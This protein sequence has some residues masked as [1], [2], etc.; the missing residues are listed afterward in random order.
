MK[1]NGEDNRFHRLAA[2]LVAR[3]CGQV[4]VDK[5]GSSIVEDDAL[6]HIVSLADTATPRELTRPGCPIDRA[7][8]QWSGGSCRCSCPPWA[9]GGEL[10]FSTLGVA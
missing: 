2:P 3:A 7:M 10:A 8:F 1:R 9:D 4:L 5:N 6:R